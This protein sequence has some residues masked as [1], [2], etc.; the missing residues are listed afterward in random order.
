VA[1]TAEVAVPSD[2]QAPVFGQAL[3]VKRADAAF[4]GYRVDAADLDDVIA[5]K[6]FLGD[7]GIWRWSPVGGPLGR[8]VDL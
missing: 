8:A 6:P 5:A 2:G 4:A 1:D 7:P 3:Q